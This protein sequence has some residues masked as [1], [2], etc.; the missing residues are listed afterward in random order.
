MVSLA[1]GLW[2]ADEKFSGSVSSSEALES[3]S[4]AH[5]S[6]DE[7][8]ALDGKRL[9]FAEEERRSN[10]IMSA[11]VVAATASLSDEPEAL[12]VPK[13]D[14]GAASVSSGPA[15]SQSASIQYTAWL[16]GSLSIRV[17]INGV[18]CQPVERRVLED[19]HHGV[20]LTCSSLKAALMNLHIEKNGQTLTLS[21]GTTRLGN[22]HPGD[23]W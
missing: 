22:L 5:P 11:P 16:K 1:D 7:P 14:P 10:A 20:G 3:P 21:R 13:V 15:R 8:A 6:A 19:S 18:P 4:M 12:E 17:I 2:A 9:F 23:T